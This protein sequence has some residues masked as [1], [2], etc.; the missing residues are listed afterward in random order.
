MFASVFIRSLAG[1]ACYS[2]CHWL[3]GEAGAA[4]YKRGGGARVCVYVCVYVCVCV[5]VCVHARC[6]KGEE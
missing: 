4:N 6:G 3:A 5:C 2:A 1:W